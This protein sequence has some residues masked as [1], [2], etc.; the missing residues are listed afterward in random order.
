MRIN[1][2]RTTYSVNTGDDVTLS[3]SIS[4]EP[5]AY[6]I[7]WI[8]SKTLIHSYYYHYT[9]LSMS[10]TPFSVNNTVYSDVRCDG[11]TDLSPSL[12]IRNVTVSD[13]G[14]YHLALTNVDGMI[15]SIPIDLN[16]DNCKYK[17]KLFW[18]LLSL[19]IKLT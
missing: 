11:G 4:S 12:D 16:V 8:Y 17:F 7:N 5:K 3:V 2:D 9:M 13:A 14:R 10:V 6:W 19:K 18:A 15:T 1:V